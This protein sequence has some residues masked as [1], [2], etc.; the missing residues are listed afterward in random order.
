M[1]KTTAPVWG[2]PSASQTVL[3]MASGMVLETVFEMATGM[4]PERETKWV[5]DWVALKG[6]LWVVASA[7]WLAGSLMQS[8]APDIL[9]TY[10]DVDR[11]HQVGP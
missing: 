7:S 6:A 2:G 5:A 4:A 1:A 9:A 11:V 8:L 10:T 3:E